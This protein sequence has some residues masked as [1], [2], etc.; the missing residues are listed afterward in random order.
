[1]S[2]RVFFAWY[3]MWIG[4]YYNRL[5]KVIYICPIPMVCIRISLSGL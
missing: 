1:M 3:D 5:A 4:L 2:I